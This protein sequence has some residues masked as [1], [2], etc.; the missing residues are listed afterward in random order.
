MSY[1]ANDH[2]V[3]TLAL[4]HDVLSEAKQQVDEE[5]AE[6]IDEVMYRVSTLQNTMRAKYGKSP[7]EKLV[8]RL[9]ED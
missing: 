6:L 2:P 1:S 4:A 7:T 8:E 9:D 5:D 3:D